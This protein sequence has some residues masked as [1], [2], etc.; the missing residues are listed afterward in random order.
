MKTLILTANFGGFDTPKTILPQSC[1][2]DF[3]SFTEKN[4][5][6]PFTSL[7]DRMK[8]KYFK[9]QTHKLFPDYDAYIWID[10]AFQIKSPLFANRMLAE[11][12]GYDV[13]VTKHPERSCIYTETEFV[14]RGLISKQAY[15]M[16]R[17]STSRIN[18]ERNYYE[19]IGYPKENGL[20]ACGLFARWNNPRVNSF[21][22]TWWD[23]TLRWSVFDQLS[24]PVL[25]YKNG[26]DVKP[27]VFDNYRAN[28]FYEIIRHAK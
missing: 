18:E 4:S 25:A 27:I 12:A 23:A 16:K 11:L 14:M 19:S 28:T 8:A 17:Y 21:F 3:L 9:I 13:A 7:D 24:F 10:S 1:S 6:F 22:D 26:I 5:P 2:S 20:Y 15:F